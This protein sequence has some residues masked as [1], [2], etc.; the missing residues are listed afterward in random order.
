[1]VFFLQLKLYRPVSCTNMFAI[2]C[3]HEQMDVN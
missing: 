1:M 3:T 2:L